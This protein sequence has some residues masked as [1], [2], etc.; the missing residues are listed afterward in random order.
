M[1]KKSE[2][3]NNEEMQRALTRIAFQIIEKN[4]GAKNII[5]AGIK[6][7]GLPLAKRI[8]NKIGSVENLFP[9][10]IELDISGFRDDLTNENIKQIEFKSI[11]NPENKIVILVDD[12]LYTG[13]TARA[14]IDAILKMGRASRIQLAVMI[15]RGH[16]ELPIRPDYVGKNL[17]TS[18]SERV[19][20]NLKEI[21]GFDAVILEKCFETKEI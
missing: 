1:K 8:S 10:V 12:V 9:K 19:C 13:R 16:R 7:R 11:S 18:Q 3:M 6:T 5:L 14:G 4:N 20:V 17:P 21:D 2:I 15:D